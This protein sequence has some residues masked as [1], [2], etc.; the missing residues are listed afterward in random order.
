M[1][2]LKDKSD[3]ALFKDLEDS[4]LTLSNCKSHRIY[5]KLQC[6]EDL[7]NAKWDAVLKIGL[8]L[9]SHIQNLHNQFRSTRD[10]CARQQNEL[11][12]AEE[13]ITLL[14]HEKK[15]AVETTE[16][17]K[18]GLAQAENQTKSLSC[19]YQEETEKNQRKSDDCR[20]KMM[21]WCH[22]TNVTNNGLKY[23]MTRIMDDRRKEQLEF[24]E[25]I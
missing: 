2:L 7:L 18:L 20:E 12:N 11:K 25:M 5:S 15:E 21:T 23:D 16:K 9:V 4:V 19:M 10:E 13:I 24:Q 8:A 1:F 14:Q 6:I 3:E 22:E 17:L